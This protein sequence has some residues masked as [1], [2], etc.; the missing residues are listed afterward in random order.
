MRRM[1][2]VQKE[3]R[4]RTLSGITQHLLSRGAEFRVSA[5]VY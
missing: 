1:K 5:A 2:K 4:L 3:E